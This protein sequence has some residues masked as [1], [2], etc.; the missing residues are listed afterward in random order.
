MKKR[1]F[2][3]KD[4]VAQNLYFKPNVK[5]KKTFGRSTSQIL[6]A[7][8]GQS[9]VLQISRSPSPKIERELQITRIFVGPQVIEF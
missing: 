3:E 4:I 8:V 9:M 2:T 7:N 6:K 1:V 5:E